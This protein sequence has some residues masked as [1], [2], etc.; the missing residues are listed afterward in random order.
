MPK[1][2]SLDWPSL[3]VI[4]QRSVEISLVNGSDLSTLTAQ[5]RLKSYDNFGGFPPQT[6]SDWDELPV[7]LCGRRG[8][9]AASRR[10]A[11][12]QSTDP[13]WASPIPRDLHR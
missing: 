1:S 6:F 8:R 7:A 10:Q 12:A 2:C 4:L 3:V 9:P 11:G 13:R 5:Q